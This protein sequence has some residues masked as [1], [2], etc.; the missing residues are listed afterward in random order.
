VWFRA[1]NLYTRAFF[2]DE[3]KCL[4][5]DDTLI[6]MT[7]N[8]VNDAAALASNGTTPVPRPDHL[9]SM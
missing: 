7:L 8:T 6:S 5:K 3:A 9:R 4:E 2:I 1:L